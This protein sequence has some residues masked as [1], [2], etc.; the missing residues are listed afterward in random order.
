MFFEFANNGILPYKRLQHTHSPFTKV[1]LF[2]GINHFHDIRTKI[3]FLYLPKHQ[4]FWKRLFWAWI[5]ENYCNSHLANVRTIKEMTL[6]DRLQ[7]TLITIK[8][9]HNETWFQRNGIFEIH[10]L[11]RFTTV[12]KIIKTVMSTWCPNVA[13]TLLNGK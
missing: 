11:Y 9:C 1:L 5:D 8:N 6:N 12:I 10:A 4:E 7:M 3:K 13:V 2:N